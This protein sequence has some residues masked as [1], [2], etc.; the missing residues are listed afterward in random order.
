M[1]EAALSSQNWEAL[2]RLELRRGDDRT[3]LV[4]IERYGPLSV[5]RPFYPEAEVCHVY[6][7]HPP[8]GVVGGDRLEL[9]LDVKK[10]A[11]AVLTTPGAGKFYLSAGARAAV[12]QQFDVAAG[13]CLEFLPQEN[14]YFAGAQVDI[15]T[16]LELEQGGCILFWEK[17]C[18]GRPANQE[19]FLSGSLVSQID[20]RVAGQLLFTEKQRVDASELARSSGFRNHAVSGSFLVYAG[21]LEAAALQQ[22]QALQP[23]HGIGGISQPQPGLLIARFLGDNSRDIDDYFMKL[24]EM[25]RPQLLQREAC[26]PRIWNT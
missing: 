21:T 5:Q 4:P 26:R 12:H 13:A 24:W 19:I 22:L 2:L 17:H 7:L 8:G 11:S 14:I 18:F 9:Q 16:S 15:K 6:L 3:R 20:L 10:D 25:L 23:E 1:S